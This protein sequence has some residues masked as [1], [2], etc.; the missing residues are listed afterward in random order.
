MTENSNFQL[1]VWF[2]NEQGHQVLA[3]YLIFHDRGVNFKINILFLTIFSK[4]KNYVFCLFNKNY[5]LRQNPQS[6]PAKLKT[7]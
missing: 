5:K 1:M 6:T 2:G 7:L 3:F 4:I